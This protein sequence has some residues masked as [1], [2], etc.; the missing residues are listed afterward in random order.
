MSSVAILPTSRSALAAPALVTKDT[1]LILPT[2]SPPSIMDRPSTASEVIPPAPCPTR[3][4][5]GKT[6]QP[7]Q[8]QAAQ[9]PAPW[10]QLGGPPTGDVGYPFY[11]A[12]SKPPGY[13]FRV[14]DLPMDTSASQVN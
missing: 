2:S 6:G 4:G 9:L 10:G 1:G 12:A 13:K 5:K 14:G 3:D 7:G 8:I 11:F